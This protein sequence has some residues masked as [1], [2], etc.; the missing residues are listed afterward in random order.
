MK[1]L[2]EYEKAYGPKSANQFGAH[3]FDA[4]L[5]LQ[6]IVPEALK[7][8][9]PGTPEF[10]AAL[11]TALETAGRIPVSQGVLDYTA[12]DHFGFTP[13]TGVLLTIDNGA[14]KLVATH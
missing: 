6:R 11:K 7:K 14:W 3:V 13:D 10:R 5:V 8:A 1:Y 12:T 9:K 2:A 4:Y